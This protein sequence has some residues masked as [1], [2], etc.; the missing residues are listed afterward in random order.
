MLARALQRVHALDPRD[1]P[2]GK[3]VP[4]VVVTHGDACL[5]NFLASNGSV[6]GYLDLGEPGLAPREHDLA[7][8]LWT[9]NYNFDDTALGREFIKA[10]GLPGLSD[11]EIRRLRESY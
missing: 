11:A 4:G 9:L 10:Y 1:C 3:R 5:P 7:A 6:T 8:A 2:F